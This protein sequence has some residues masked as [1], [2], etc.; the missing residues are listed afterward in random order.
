MKEIW[1]FLCWNWQSWEGWQKMFVFAMFLQGA[2]WG[3]SSGL[4][5]YVS[6]L[7]AG[8]ILSYLLKWIVW[9]GLKSSWSKYKSHRNELLTTIKESDK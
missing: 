4:G 9:D 3:M 6:G 7:G 1:S 5:M 2:G 8:I